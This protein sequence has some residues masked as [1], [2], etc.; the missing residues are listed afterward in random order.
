MTKEEKQAVMAEFARSEGDVGSSE[1]Q[2]AVLTR[3]ITELTAHMKAHP[4]DHSTRRSLIA[5]VNRRRRLLN[6]LRRRN[7]A[8]Y[9]DIV[10]KLSLR[11]R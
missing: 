8:S 11:H 6:Y 2:I 1:V 9:K 4:H 7:H 10:R 5:K 3:R